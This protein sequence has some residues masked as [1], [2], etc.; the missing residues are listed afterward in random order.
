MQW[1]T[2]H[3]LP[4]LHQAQLKEVGLAQNW[5]TMT[6]IYLKIAQPFIF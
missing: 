5:E 1:T 2:F 3:S 4:D 6:L